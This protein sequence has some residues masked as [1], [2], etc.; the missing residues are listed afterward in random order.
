MSLTIGD[1]IG[2][3][4]DIWRP[5][6]TPLQ[7]YNPPLLPP[8]S[9]RY[10]PDTSYHPQVQAPGTASQQGQGQGGSSPYAIPAGST[11]DQVASG[12]QA[13]PFDVT[14]S[15]LATAVYETRGAPPP[16]WEAV[17]DQQLLDQGVADPQAWRLQYLGANDAVP[18][19]DQEFRADA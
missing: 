6:Q 8:Q 5:Q 4:Q 12:T 14:L 15:Q 2:G 3:V 19:N 11:L 1:D 7:S 13:Q 9:G 16:G 18:S 10:R 17:S